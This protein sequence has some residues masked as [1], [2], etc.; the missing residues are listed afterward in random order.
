MI[1]IDRRFGRL[2]ATPTLTQAGTHTHV[3]TLTHTHS[4]VHA[5][6]LYIVPVGDDILY[7][8]MLTAV[9]MSHPL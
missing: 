4:H 1:G 6:L 3:H 2:H 7:T 5:L 9:P 8:D